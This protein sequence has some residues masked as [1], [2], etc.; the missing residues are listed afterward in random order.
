LS[1]AS[2]TTNNSSSHNTNQRIKRTADNFTYRPLLLLLLLTRDRHLQ[3]SFRKGGHLLTSDTGQDL[4]ERRHDDRIADGHGHF[5]SNF[6]TFSIV[7]FLQLPQAVQLFN[8]LTFNARA[9][10]SQ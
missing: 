7:H 9:G 6:T 10:N 4:V 1:N 2:A 5:E 8:V 3:T